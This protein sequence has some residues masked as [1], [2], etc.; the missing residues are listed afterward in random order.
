MIESHAP[1]DA[2]EVKDVVAAKQ[3]RYGGCQSAVPAG[4][5]VRFRTSLHTTWTPPS[6]ESRI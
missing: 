5:A 4:G 2:E 6:V 3:T 1:G